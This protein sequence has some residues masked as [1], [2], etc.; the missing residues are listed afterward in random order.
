[1]ACSA[2]I[3]SRI[4]LASP[5][6]RGI[7]NSAPVNEIFSPVAASRTISTVSRIRVSGRPNATP[8][9]PSITCGPD[10]PR[11]SRNRPPEMFD[12]VIAARA[13]ATGVRVPSWMI[14]DPSSMRSVRAARYPSADGASAP[15][16]SAT[17]QIS[18][19]S[20]SASRPNSTVSGQFPPEASIV[21]A[22][23]ITRPPVPRPAP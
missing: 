7:V 21:V 9:S 16:A 2:R 18:R 10:V 8:C 15:H 17:Q 11:P 3:D 13:M 22:V 23:R 14:P 19:P 6:G 4:G 12:K 1:M 20:F 5:P